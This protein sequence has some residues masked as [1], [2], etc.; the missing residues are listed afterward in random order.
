MKVGT[1]HLFSY[2]WL[3]LSELQQNDIF[4]AHE[5]IWPETKEKFVK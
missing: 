5:K 4:E 1:R 3:S 2:L